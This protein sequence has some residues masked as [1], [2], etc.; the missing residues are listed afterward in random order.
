MPF[1][2]MFQYA[3][4]RGH[5]TGLEGFDPNVNVR[6]ETWNLNEWRWA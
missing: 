6:I 5:K 4:L 2:P 1:L 3:N